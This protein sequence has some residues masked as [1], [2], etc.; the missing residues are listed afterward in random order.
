MGQIGARLLAAVGIPTVVFLAAEGAARWAL[1]PREYTAAEIPFESDPD[2]G[3]RPAA[4]I[5]SKRLCISSLST[6]GRE[7]RR[8]ASRRILVVG[9]SMVFGAEV[10]ESDTFCSVLQAKLGDDVS[11]VNAGCPGYG[12]HEY[13]L[14]I[15]R[16]A[17]LIQPTEIVA[18]VFL[19]NDVQDVLAT[20]PYEV[21][22][23]K[24]VSRPR[25]EMA[26]VP[27]RAWISF[28]ARVSSLALLRAARGGLGREALAAAEAHGAG[29]GPRGARLP[30]RGLC[31]MDQPGLKA[32]MI[33]ESYTRLGEIGG[34]RIQQAWL[35]LPDA[36][37]AI[38]EEAS[39]AGAKLTFV[40]LPMP[41]AYDPGLR[42]RLAKLW[43]LPPRVVDGARPSRELAALLAKRSLS[44]IDLTPM[45]AASPAE[46]RLHVPSDLHFS[47]EGHALVGNALA[48]RLSGR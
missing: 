41:V 47:V 36:I 21:L 24:L 33:C 20:R 28:A 22:G 1:G 30:E 5:Q 12:L 27:E 35:A 37:G 25:Y 18:C 40:L 39:K 26:G 44:Y 42:A 38:D 32:L 48:A 10:G 31:G 46:H 11:V 45:L 9:D 7:P 2:L 23:E 14:A 8:D 19:G 13:R 15:R 34:D 6:R 29:V 43:N 4:G 3:F 17:P 16:L